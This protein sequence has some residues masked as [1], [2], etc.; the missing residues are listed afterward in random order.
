MSRETLSLY[1]LFIIISLL[2][3]V[4]VELALILIQDHILHM[5]LGNMI[6]AFFSFFDL[7]ETRGQIATLVIYC[8]PY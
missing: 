4:S 8:I 3:I 7:F 2:D 6:E 5:Y 1:K